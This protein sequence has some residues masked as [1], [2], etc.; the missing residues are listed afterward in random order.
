MPLSHDHRLFQQLKGQLS[1]NLREKHPEVPENIED[2]KGKDIALFQQDLMEKVNGRVSEKWFYTHIKNS[3]GNI[4][5]LDILNLLSEYTGHHNWQTFRARNR[6]LVVRKISLGVILLPVGVLV[7]LLYLFQFRPGNYQ[8]CLVDAYSQKSLNAADVEVWQ[9]KNGE[10][11]LKV[12]LNDAGCFSLKSRDKQVQLVITGPYVHSDTLLR[13]FTQKK[14]RET[15][16]VRSNDYAL[17][18]SAFSRKDITDWQ[19]RRNQLDFMIADNAVIF[20]LLPGEML[21]MEMYNKQEF[22]D[23]M[24]TPINSLKNIR[25]VEIRHW[26]DQITE[27]KFVQENQDMP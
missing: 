2:W 1:Q 22:I 24:T 21:S 9:M 16:E 11:P 3:N 26:Q 8:F 6:K 25:I 10:S 17:M 27:M 18:I 19:R 14:G 20:Q 13:T 15:I 4:P 7:I 12:K 5:R 23:K